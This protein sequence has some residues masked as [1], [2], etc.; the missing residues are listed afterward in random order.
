MRKNKEGL[1]LVHSTLQVVL[2][3]K[4]KRLNS[5]PKKPKPITETETK[6]PLVFAC[7]FVV[8]A[9]RI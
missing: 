9:E 3:T 6:Y 5:L 4:S 2:L 8:R 7:L 1:T